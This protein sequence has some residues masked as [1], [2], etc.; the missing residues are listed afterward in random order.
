ME[1]APRHFFVYPGY[2]HVPRWTAIVT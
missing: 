1:K 2:H